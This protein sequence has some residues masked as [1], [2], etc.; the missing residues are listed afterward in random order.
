MREIEHFERK[1]GPEFSGPFSFVITTRYFS[2]TSAL[3]SDCPF[4][5]PQPVTRS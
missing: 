4:G 1:K 3:T 2:P 5:L